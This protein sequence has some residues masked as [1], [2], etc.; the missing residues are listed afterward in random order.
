MADLVKRVFNSIDSSV[1]GI[2]MTYVAGA[3]G[4]LISVNYLRSLEK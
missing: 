4:G 2:I 3:T 1:Y